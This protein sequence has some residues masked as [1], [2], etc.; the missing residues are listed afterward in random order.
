M[1][2]TMLQSLGVFIAI[3]LLAGFVSFD[4]VKGTGLAEWEKQYETGRFARLELSQRGIVY[5]HCI[6][7]LKSVAHNSFGL[8]RPTGFAI[9]GIFLVQNLI[10]L[11]LSYRYMRQLDLAPISCLV[12]L[13]ALAWVLNHLASPWG[14]YF[15]CILMLLA[16]LSINARFYWPITMIA[17]AEVFTTGFIPISPFLLFFK[18]KKLSTPAIIALCISVPIGAIY[19]AS[20]VT[21]L[22]NIKLESSQL[23]KGVSPRLFVLLYLPLN[24]LP[25]LAL[26]GVMTKTWPEQIKNIEKVFYATVLTFVFQGAMDLSLWALLV[27]VYLPMALLKVLGTTPPL[28]KQEAT[29]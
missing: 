2:K 23:Y 11:L 25:I 6:T 9:V 4:Q 20:Y 10:L 24:V 15:F 26:S 21:E 12:G 14:P 16:L 7:T 18:E 1:S 5:D 3:L 19:W 17:V 27:L 29:P 13:S 28:S 8:A 22:E